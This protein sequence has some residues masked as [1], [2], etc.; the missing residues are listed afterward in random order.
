MPVEPP[1]Q[2]PSLSVIVA[3]RNRAPAL[4][5]CLDA[6]AAQDF[7]GLNAE[8]VVVDNASTDATP[9][10]L[11]EE[12]SRRRLPLKVV[13]EPQLG[14]SHARNAGIQQASGRF[15][16]FLDDDALATPRWLAAYERLFRQGRPVVQGRIR[17]QLQGARPRYLADDL[18]AYLT[19]LDKDE[20][21]GRYEGN[22]LGANFGAMR[23]VYEQLG[24]FRCDLGAGASGFGEDTEF[25]QRMTAAGIPVI[26]SPDALV[27]HQIPPDRATRRAL[28][29]RCY[30]SGWSQALFQEFPGSP[31]RTLFHFARLSIAHL[32]RI[33]F[34]RRSAQRVREMCQWAEHAG[35]VRQ[36]LKMRRRA[37]K[38][39]R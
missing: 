35:R 20:P 1:T 28:L 5:R 31:P 39:G 21:E 26:Y 17:V 22:L 30:L 2:R 36:I 15:I 13:A 24:P 6:L 18:L 8:L 4:R 23:G 25:S 38:G 19:H 37:K 3:T 9:Q 29:R 16:I 14:L 12:L 27:L 10:A 11:A 7:R 33:V 34:A 32:G